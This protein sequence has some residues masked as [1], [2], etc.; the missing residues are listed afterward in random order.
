VNRNWIIVLAVIGVL[1]VFGLCCVGAIA[2]FGLWSTI[3][4]TSSATE[5]PRVI[6]PPPQWTPEAPE[7]VLPEP[8]FPTPEIKRPTPQ[9]VDPNS[10][11]E[12]SPIPGIA[13]TLELLQ[14]TVVPVSDPLDLAERLQGKLD[15]SST[16]PAP[17]SFLSQG[18]QR[19]FWVSDSDTNESSQIDATLQYVTDHV[20][21]W[22]EDGVDFDL[23]DLKRLADTF[24][25]E[26]YPTN[27]AFFGSEWTPGVDGDP[28][29]YILYSRG[30]GFSIAGYFSSADEVPPEA[31]PH[32]NAAE[33]FLLSAD[34]VVLDEEYAYS[35]LAHEFQHMIHWYTDR[36]EES[37]VNEGFS[38]LAAFLN[39]YSTGG[40]EYLYIQDPDIQLT[41]WPTV[42]EERDAH[43][44]ASFLFVNYFLDRFGED[45]T[46]ALVAEASNGMTSIDYVLQQLG[47]TDPATGE[48]AQADDVFADWVLANLILDDSV[49]D[50]RYTYN[51]YR[52]APQA[53]PSEE[54][55]DCPT[56][57]IVS[58]VNQYGVDYFAIRCD[59]EYTLHFEGSTV[60]PLVGG[61]PHSGNYAFWSNMGDESNM[62][63]TRQFDFT[64]VSGPLDLNYWTWFDIEVDYDY[65]YLEVS[66]DGETWKILKTPSS[67]IENPSG[68]SY[69]WG[70]TGPSGDDPAEWIQET[71][72]LSEYAGKK[73]WLRFEYVTD[74]AVH[75]EGLLVDDI[76]IP[77]IDYKEDFEAGDG[78]WEAAGFVRVQ[79]TLPQSFELSL[80]T[81]G[82]EVTVQRLELDPTNTLDIP[83]SI[84]GKVDQVILVVSG[85]TRFTRQDA[86]YQFNISP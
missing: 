29:L 1:G 14:N 49:G 80:V 22:V 46:Q 83:V 50:G 67:T 51:N 78:D 24:E 69:G 53:E 70:Y 36:N 20:Y 2:T 4:S 62:T 54:I 27:R 66:E 52:Q 40:A 47:I 76:E 18:A 60:V 17:A 71:V 35:V 15:L 5:I 3:N 68:N 73:V 11:A 38:E 61:D 59:G 13:E 64:N 8:V 57:D 25:K 84:G 44:G 75:G 31:H 21:F 9:V 34:N 55:N 10:N 81:V 45:A 30:L 28:H 23:R 43:Y 82:D 39:G 48:I 37:W 32:S 72:D 41:D 7:N 58:A 85:T 42:P 6:N 79:N 63:M 26:I 65:V 56:Q 16:V 12:N 77:Q 74:A 19:S 86:T 33:M